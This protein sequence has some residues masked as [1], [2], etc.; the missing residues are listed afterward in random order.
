M[1]ILKKAFGQY[2]TNCYILKHSSGEIII[3]PG[4]GASE[5][6]QSQCDHPLAILC[7]HG[8][9]DHIWDNAKLKA[10][11]P[12]IPL[13]CHQND[14]FMLQSDCFGLDM[15]PCAPDMTLQGEENL[16]SLGDFEIRFLL[17]AGHTPGSCMIQTQDHLFS[18]DFIFYHCI[19]RTDFEYSDPKA[20]KQSLQR[21]KSFTPNL[22]IHPGHGEDTNVEEE[23]AHVDVWIKRLEQE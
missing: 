7:T 12:N 15:E 17:F 19:G 6:I 1:K 2:R 9:F 3:D 22:P 21:F 5:W 14:A 23:Q 8:H 11:F 18:G 13:I 10:R 20:M 16:L 4:M